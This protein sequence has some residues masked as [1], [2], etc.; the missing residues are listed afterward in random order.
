MILNDTTIK[1]F[2]Q[3]WKIKVI[4]PEFVK[5]DQII[6]SINWSSFD[7]T[8][9]NDFKIFPKQSEIIDPFNNYSLNPFE[10]DLSKINILERNIEDWQDLLL[11]PWCFMLWH[12]K[13]RIWLPDD[14]CA[15]VDWRSSIAR[16]WILIHITWWFINPWH[17]FD[18]PFK[19]TLE[20]KNLNTVPVILRPWM[21]ICQIIFEMLNA[22]CEYAYNKKYTAKY[23]WQI[24]P[25][26]S[27]LYSGW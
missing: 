8:L 19:L 3:I 1:R 5:I 17:G 9:W 21:R 24:D 18:T 23:N 11:E 7:L 25:T 12:T 14:I 22:P 27:R 2:M 10:L 4:P 20:I 15:R 13:E 6:E 16:L 26:L